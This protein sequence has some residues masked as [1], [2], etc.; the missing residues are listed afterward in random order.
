[1]ATRQ[2]T[3]PRRRVR[4]ITQLTPYEESIWKLHKAGLSNRQIADQ[5]N[6][7]CSIRSISS[8]LNTIRDKNQAREWDERSKS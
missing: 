1:M 7:Q 2:S 5:L 3:G 8:T 6:L 4:D